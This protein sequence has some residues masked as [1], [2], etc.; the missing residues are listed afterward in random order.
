MDGQV[1]N[2]FHEKGRPKRLEVHGQKTRCGR[3]KGSKW[4]VQKV[5]SGQS[6]RLKV[7]GSEIK[8]ERSKEPQWT[9]KKTQ[10]RRS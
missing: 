5:K 2:W 3:P 4:T 9:V 8:N 7:D 10:C 1:L 6:K